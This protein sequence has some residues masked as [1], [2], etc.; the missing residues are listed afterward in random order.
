VASLDDQSRPP[1]SSKLIRAA[2][3]AADAHVIGLQDFGAVERT[4]VERGA[5]FVEP[6]QHNLSALDANDRNLRS[7]DG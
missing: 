2:S 4:P 5:Q 1:S 6:A 3:N 7:P